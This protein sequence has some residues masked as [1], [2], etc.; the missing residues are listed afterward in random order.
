[1]EP[2]KRSFVAVI[3]DDYSCTGKKSRE[4]S[5]AEETEEIQEEINLGEEERAK[6]IALQWE[7]QNDDIPDFEPG[8]IPFHM[9][10][11]KADG[12][13]VDSQIVMGDHYL[14]E[15]DMDF[16]KH[17]F[18]LAS[19]QGHPLGYFGVTKAMKCEDADLT[20]AFKSCIIAAII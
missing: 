1:M 15:G 3:D 13:D 17:Y 19:D 14:C 6:R 10:K 16:A 12:G 5:F 8:S 20:L 18:Q 11:S 9:W 2:N 7:K 4:T